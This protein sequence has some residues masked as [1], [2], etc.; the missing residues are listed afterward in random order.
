MKIR[1]FLGIGFALCVGLA[2]IAAAQG[3][4]PAKI[5]MKA[6]AAHFE[7]QISQRKLSEALAAFK[8][9]QAKSTE[10][11]AKHNEA[12]AKLLEVLTDEV[13]RLGAENVELRR[14]IRDIA[15]LAK[16]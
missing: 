15:S 10:A 7:A 12:Q 3:D 6:S 9:A 2:A 1:A 4:P 16:K 14:E 8:L 5:E 13:A 11:Q